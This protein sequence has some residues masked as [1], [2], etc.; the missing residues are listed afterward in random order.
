VHVGNRTASGKGGLGASRDRCPPDDLFA[1]VR[2]HP[3][4][5]TL[6]EFGDP[7]PPGRA[8]QRQILLRGDAVA[9]TPANVRV[10][11]SGAN[12]GRDV[13]ELLRGPHLDAASARR[14]EY[15][16]GGAFPTRRAYTASDPRWCAV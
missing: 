14:H 9:Q 6:D 2:Q 11:S 13:I 12:N 5:S 16:I 7:F 4:R 8:A 15:S 10:G 3:D 1:I